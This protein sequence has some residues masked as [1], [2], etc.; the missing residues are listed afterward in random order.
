LPWTTPTLK[1]TRRLTRD[2]VLSQLGAKA[3][4]PNSALRIMSDA[5]AG[6]ANLVM[7]YLDWLA[8]QLLPDTAEREWLDRHGNIWLVNADGSKGR[9]AATYA[10]GTVQFTGNTN[11]IVP[12]GTLLFGANS[13][14]YQTVTE[15][16][17]GSSGTGT[18][19]AAALTA[20]SVSNLPDGDVVG[21]V[22]PIAGIT[23]A[24]LLGDMTGGINEESDEQLRERILFRIQNPP[25]GGSQADYERWAMEVPGVTRAWAASEQGA[26][27]ITTRFLMDDLRA[28][29]NGWPTHADVQIVSDYMD[30][31]R[32][33]TVMECYVFAPMITYLD[34]TIA[35]LTTDDEATRTA[36][37]ESISNMLFARA[38]PGQTIYRSWVEEAI[39][40]AIGEDHH[41]L[42]FETAPMPSLGHM[43]VLS[44]VYFRS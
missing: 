7:L 1:E 32:P 33:V 3:M 23:S 27:T 21:I 36:I 26:G 13:V 9:K 18:A 31:K 42:E 25:M 35:N 8:K 12:V 44:T 30:T 4:I 43:A 10:S 40:G 39:G 34:M 37:I 6:L 24:A 11:F 5:M 41:E 17:I 29:S 20:G 19:E 15:V 28:D 16:L 2:Y 38:K 22:T 14:Q